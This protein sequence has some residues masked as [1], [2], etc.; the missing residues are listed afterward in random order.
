MLA[1]EY[2]ARMLAGTN[3]LPADRMAS[4]SNAMMALQGNTRFA[5]PPDEVAPDGSVGSLYGWLPYIESFCLA[6]LAVLG[7]PG[8][9]AVWERMI[10]AMS[11]GDRHPCDTRLMYRP[12]SG[13]PSWGAFYMTAPA[14]WLV[15]DALLDFSYAPREGVLRL[16]PQFQGRFAVVHPLFWGQGQRDGERLSLRVR[17][18][19]ASAAPVINWLETA[20]GVRALRVNGTR[21]ESAGQAGVYARFKIPAF[22]L[23]QGAELTWEPAQ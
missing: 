21:V 3:V 22:V 10:R 2:F 15:Y 11:G 5:V 17:K 12:L 8:V 19:F 18:L 13:E 14:S 23:Q 16:V 7:Q 9:L 4:C 1:G 20:P 6:P